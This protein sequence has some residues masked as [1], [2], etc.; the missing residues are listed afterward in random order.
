VKEG[1]M[2]AA[3]LRLPRSSGSATA[4]EQSAGPEGERAQAPGC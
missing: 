3:L 1:G 4:G 2:P